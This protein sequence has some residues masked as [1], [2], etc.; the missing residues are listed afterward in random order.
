MNKTFNDNEQ[1]KFKSILKNISINLYKQKKNNHFFFSSIKLNED[2]IYFIIKNF[3]ILVG[4]GYNENGYSTSYIKILLLHFYMSFQNFIGSNL[5]KLK[6]IE[7]ICFKNKIENIKD[8]YNKKSKN[9]EI[10]NLYEY[11]YKYIIYENYL[12]I[13]LYHNF[14]KLFNTLLRYESIKISTF[15]LKNI[16]LYDFNT[17]KFLLSWDDINNDILTFTNTIYLNKNSPIFSEILYQSTT[18]FSHYIYENNLYYKQSK[19]HFIKL[20]LTS[21]FPRII[22]LIKYLPILKGTVIIYVYSQFK[23]SRLKKNNS[24]RDSTLN[25]TKYKE[26]D[27]LN[28]EDFK[29]N[30]HNMDYRFID[31]G[32]LLYIEK[33]LL[34]YLIGNNGKFDNFFDEGK[35]LKYYDYNIIKDLKIFMLNE[36]EEIEEKNLDD[37][38]KNLDLYLKEKYLNEKK[39]KKKYTV[40]NK[41]LNYEIEKKNTFINQRFEKLE[42]LLIIQPIDALYKLTKNNMIL[43]SDNDDNEDND[44]FMKSMNKSSIIEKDDKNNS[45]TIESL[46]HDEFSLNNKSFTISNLHISKEISKVEKVEKVEKNKEISIDKNNL[47]F[48]KIDSELDKTKI[49]YNKDLN[50]N[51]IYSH[52][53]LISEEQNLLTYQINNNQNKKE[54]K[55]LILLEDIK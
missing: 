35:I 37:K 54:T 48:Y 26:F 42:N 51:R 19:Y 46:E 27:I 40:E 12:I 36:E 49:V 23:L 10:N 24:I 32:Y 21:T 15:Y 11:Y 31:I 14:T 33:F 4:I 20:E 8:L 41:L 18:L 34:E 3:F 2:K 44:S 38:I 5:N 43:I 9:N 55:K 47:D 13:S 1:I 30:F 29:N 39:I 6:E 52:E 50:T 16:Y 25:I 28:G 17:N 22:L 53:N 7:N 45:N